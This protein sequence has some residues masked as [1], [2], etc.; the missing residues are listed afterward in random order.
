MA[1]TQSPLKFLSPAWF[2]IVMGLCGLSLAWLRAAPLMG[3]VTGHLA[4]AF[5]G[6][7]MLVFLALAA[8]SAVR[9]Q[10]HPEAWASDCAHPVRHTFLATVPVSLIL[11]ATVAVGLFGMHTAANAVW[12][13][14]SLS[15]LGVTLWVVSRW[16]RGN[17]TSGLQWQVVTPA[18]IIPVVGNVLVPLAGVALGHT[19]W[20]AAQFGIG[21]LFWP[22]VLALLLVRIAVQGMWPERLMPSV[23]ILVAPPA[24]VGLSALQLGAP[25]VLGWMLWGMALFS[26]LWAAMLA[27]RIVAQAFTIAHWG[28]SFPMAALAGLT[29]QLATPSGLLAVLAPMLLALT[30][31]VVFGLGMGT[32]RGLRQ[33]TLLAPEPVAM[34]QPV[35]TE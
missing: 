24:V 7:A 2:S 25:P 29:A 30:S 3:D 6:L 11:L 32:V 18:L 5:G 27:K 22:L 15:Q 34:I 23:F 16:W 17:K 1:S 10:R 28:L 8:M 14:G 9:L 35:G 19:E 31:L 4:I 20:S 33:G 26:F 21:V 13:V 12:W